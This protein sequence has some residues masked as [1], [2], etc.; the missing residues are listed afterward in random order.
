MRCIKY[1]W[2]TSQRA[3]LN[4]AE[5]TRYFFEV[6]YLPNCILPKHLNSL[7][8]KGRTVDVDVLATFVSYSKSGIPKVKFQTTDYYILRLVCK[9]WCSILPY[10][11]LKVI[12]EEKKADVRQLTITATLF[13]YPT[14]LESPPPVPECLREGQGLMLAPFVG[15]VQEGPRATAQVV[16]RV[17]DDEVFDEDSG[18][19]EIEVFLPPEALEPNLPIPALVEP[20]PTAAAPASEESEAETETD[21]DYIFY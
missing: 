4:Y 16:A 20:N 2:S 11:R 7:T 18:V 13:Y 21:L 6:I 19:E 3:S 9:S 10:L 8:R 5:S 15:L 1:R 17:E 14:Q 12:H